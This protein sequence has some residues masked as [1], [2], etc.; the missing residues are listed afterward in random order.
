MFKGIRLILKAR[1]M[2]I[3]QEQAAR[4]ERALNQHGYKKSEGPPKR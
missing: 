2:R 4:R 3:L 1:K